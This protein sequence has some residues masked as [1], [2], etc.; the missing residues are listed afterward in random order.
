MEQFRDLFERI[1][2]RQYQRILRLSFPHDD[3]PAALLVVDSL[4]ATESLSRDFAFTLELLSDDPGIPL[5][6]LQGKLVAVELVRGDGTLRYFTGH[7]FGFGLL[8]QDG[9]VARY[10]A[11]VGPWLQ[12]LHLRRDSRL[13]HNANLHEQ[14][15]AIFAAYGACVCWEDRA[16]LGPAMSVACQFEESDHNYLSRR[17]EAAGV[18]YWYEHDARGHRLILADDSTANPVIDG[19]A[20]VTYQQRGGAQHE[21]SL[22][23]WSG[24]RRITP[25]GVTLGSVDFKFASRQGGGRTSSGASRNAQGD[26]PDLSTYE[27]T[28]ARGFATATTA[29]GWRS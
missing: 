23:D 20:T 7:I 18:F 5:K 22:S 2:A 14:A 21:D 27:Y 6:A 24:A 16:V 8:S 29:I 13:F 4:E 10:Q 3:G 9:V 19:D 17:W 25:T 12:Y 26:V 28:G 11:R 15:D 1:A